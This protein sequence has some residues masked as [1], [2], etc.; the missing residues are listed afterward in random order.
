M[1]GFVDVFAACVLAHARQVGED[2]IRTILEEE[3][4]SHFVF[5]NAGFRWKAFSATV[6]ET[7]LA[8]RTFATSFGSCSFDEPLDDLRALGWI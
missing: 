7:Q 6:E 1:H 3:D 5:T 8:R 2:V 4:S